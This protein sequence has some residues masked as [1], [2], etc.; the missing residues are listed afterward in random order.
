[1]INSSGL[2]NIQNRWSSGYDGGFAD[3]PQNTS[4]KIIYARTHMKSSLKFH[5]VFI[6]NQI[7]TRSK[8]LI[9]ATSRILDKLCF[10]NISTYDE[11]KCLFDRKGDRENWNLKKN[12]DW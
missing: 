11:R 4:K 9:F 1:M 5:D 6:D 2:S 7:C 12:L 10:T 3:V 8:N